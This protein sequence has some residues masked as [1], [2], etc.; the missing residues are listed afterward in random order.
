V[1]EH[2]DTDSLFDGARDGKKASAVGDFV[3]GGR[4][5]EQ[6]IGLGFDVVIP[7]WRV[8]VG[9]KD[10]FDLGDGV[11]RDEDSGV[12]GV[13]GREELV[14]GGRGFR[15]G[16]VIGVLPVHGRSPVRLIQM[17]DGVPNEF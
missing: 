14:L 13:E 11:F 16:I 8:G 1:D 7:S 9:F 3:V 10:G 6:I 17:V 12:V 5:I 15:S 4:L 2:E